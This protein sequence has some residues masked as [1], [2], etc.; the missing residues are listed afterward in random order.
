[1]LFISG[2]T[3][4]I[5]AQHGILRD[6]VAL[7]EKPFSTSALAHKIRSLLDGRPAG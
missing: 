5:V 4:D 3:D 1:V 2:Y 6:G 7:L